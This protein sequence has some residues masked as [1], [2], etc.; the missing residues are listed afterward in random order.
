MFSDSPDPSALLPQIANNEA[1]LSQNSSNF[2][3]LVPRVPISEPHPTSSASN[4]LALCPI[5]RVCKALKHCQSP[6][7]PLS[8]MLTFWCAATQIQV[9][10]NNKAITTTYPNYTLRFRVCYPL[11][12][13]LWTH[14][15]REYCDNT[16]K[17]H[18]SCQSKKPRVIII[19]QCS[20]PT[21]ELI[22]YIMKY[23]CYTKDD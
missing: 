17:G 14:A 13:R 10:T 22:V 6:N 11:M 9:Q 7:E 18:A 20:N 4:P 5:F 19:T 12:D 2:S 23:W 8:F 15:K 21:R 3:A 1:P 16:N